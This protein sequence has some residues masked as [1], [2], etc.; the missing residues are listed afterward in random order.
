MRLKLASRTED[1]N[2]RLLIMFFGFK[3]SIMSIFGASFLVKEV[4]HWWAELIRMLVIL[5]CKS[6]TLRMA[7]LRFLEP[8]FLREIFLC[9]RLR[10]CM[11]F[12]YDFG[13]VMTSPNEVIAK[14]FTVSTNHMK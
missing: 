13:L 1:A 2:L 12:L 9:Q 5:R 6:A 11:C 14:S 4:V 10:R 8:F 3:D 7:F